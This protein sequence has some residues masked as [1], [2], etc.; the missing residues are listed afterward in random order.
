MKAPIVSLCAH[1]ATKF[2][3]IK[4][5]KGSLQEKVQRRKEGDPSTSKGKEVVGDYI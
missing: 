1:K 4:V 3:K 2:V 5:S